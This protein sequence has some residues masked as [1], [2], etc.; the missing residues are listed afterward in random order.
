[1]PK[2]GASKPSKICMPKTNPN[3]F[4]PWSIDYHA[5]DLHDAIAAYYEK[6]P[7]ATVKIINR[8]DDDDNSSSNASYD[9]NALYS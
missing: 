2:A 8:H 3:A 5:N 6:H 7:E 9:T 4:Q 1:M